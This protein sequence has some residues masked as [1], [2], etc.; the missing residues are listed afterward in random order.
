MSGK[1]CVN[2]TTIQ[3]NKTLVDCEV[4]VLEE[5]KSGGSCP[6]SAGGHFLYGN[7]MS[8]VGTCECCTTDPTDPANVEDAAENINIFKVGQK[9]KCFIKEKH[10]AIIRGIF[11][12]TEGR[13]L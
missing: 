8:N 12:T 5:Q 9:E 13:S 10:N 3:E 4:K 1:T 7:A 6:E 2:K 11:H